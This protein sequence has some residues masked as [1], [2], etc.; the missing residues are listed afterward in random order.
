MATLY[1]EFEEL[2]PRDSNGRSITG[3]MLYGIAEL[4][5]DNDSDWHVASV[6]LENA[7]TIKHNATAPFDAAIFKIVADE[8]SDSRTELGEM[9]AEQFAA[10]VEEDLQDREDAKADYCFEMA[11]AS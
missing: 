8:I 4:T 2:C 6:T 9:A 11:R 1:F 7:A 5:D 10:A 3:M